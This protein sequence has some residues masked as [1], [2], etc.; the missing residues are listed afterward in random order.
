MSKQYSEEQIQEAIE[1]LKKKRPEHANREQAINFL[2]TT[3]DF[4]E[5]FVT[6]AQK[7]LKKKKPKS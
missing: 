6:V 3:Q 7:K 4:A 2:N 1:I 5:V